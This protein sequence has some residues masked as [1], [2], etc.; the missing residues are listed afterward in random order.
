[1]TD[2]NGPGERSDGDW[3]TVPVVRD[4][5]SASERLARMYPDLEQRDPQRWAAEIDE[6]L[7]DRD[8][9]FWYRERRLLEMPVG[10]TGWTRPWALRAGED[11]L[12]WLLDEA[13]RPGDERPEGTAQLKLTRHALEFE[14]WWPAGG[15]QI[16]RP[17]P[18]EEGKPRLPVRVVHGAPALPSRPRRPE[19]TGDQVET[20]RMMSALANRR[21]TLM[22]LSATELAAALDAAR[23]AHD[24][25]S[26]SMLSE[27]AFAFAERSQAVRI[28]LGVLDRA[29]VGHARSDVDG[30][31][32]DRAW[33][34]VVAAG[35]RLAEVLRPLGDLRVE[36]ELG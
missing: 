25:I 26:M 21:E 23:P 29:R 24:T 3:S 6:M 16:E 35:R 34:V 22:T 11:G 8:H 2:Y 17:H 10:G 18:T 14:V 20:V 1:M 19:M 31:Y 28:A 27:A 9:I 13:Y 12:Y 5:Q 15:G 33:D 4:R 32:S 30:Q 36:R 7:D